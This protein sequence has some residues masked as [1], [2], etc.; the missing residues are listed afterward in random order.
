MACPNPECRSEGPFR[1][2]CTS[3]FLVYDDGTDEHEDVQWDGESSCTCVM[4]GEGG[5][6]QD[7]YTKVW[8]E[9]PE[10]NFD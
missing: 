1:I 4:C 5:R 3:T 8:L 9:W 2:V 6:V 7:F 10:D